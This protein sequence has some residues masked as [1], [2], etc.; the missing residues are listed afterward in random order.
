[1]SFKPLIMALTV[2]TVVMPITIP[3]IVSADLSGFFRNVSRA[4]SIS[5]RNFK[6]LSFRARG[7]TGSA[8]VAGRVFW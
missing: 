7:R 2:M 1:L 3:K 5:S 4:S 8:M 6:V